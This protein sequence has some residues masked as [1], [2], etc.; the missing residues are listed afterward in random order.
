M[1]SSKTQQRTRSVSYHFAA[2]LLA[3]VFT[4]LN[5]GADAARADT[6]VDNFHTSSSPFRNIQQTGVGSNV[7]T[8]SGVPQVIG[9]TRQTTVS[10]TGGAATARARIFNGSPGNLQFTSSGVT[11][12]M[13]L[14]YNNAG[15]GLAANIAPFMGV[16]I[17]FVSVALPATAPTLPVTVTLTDGA[18]NSA[19]ATVAVTSTGAQTLLIDPS[20]FGAALA[21][22]DLSNIFSI[23]LLFDAGLGQEFSLSGPITLLT[24][25]PL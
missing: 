23:K 24:P 12:T 22:L 14:V 13:S 3:A 7:N 9:G 1:L 17:P 2:G 16:S 8:E 10:V 18:A 21:S 20:A 6:V 5:I 19:S 11:S 15:A 4:V 25:E